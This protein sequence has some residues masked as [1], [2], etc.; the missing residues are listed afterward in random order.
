S[1]ARL[2]RICPPPATAPKDWVLGIDFGTTGVRAALVRLGKPEIVKLGRE[3]VLPA[4]VALDDQGRLLVGAR[5]KALEVER[6]AQVVSGAKRWL[7][8]RLDAATGRR[9]AFALTQDDRGEIAAEVKGQPLTMTRVCAELLRQARQLAQETLGTQLLRAVIGVPAYFNE[10]QRSALRRAAQQAG[11]TVERLVSEPTAAAIAHAATHGLPR[12]RLL[13]V[14]FGGG[15]FDATVLEVE[16]D[17]FEVVATGGDSFLGG[18]DFD[19]RIANL[20]AERFEESTG[21]SL[22][23]DAVAQ[24]RLRLAAETAKI[25]LSS[26]T[27]AQVALPFLATRDGAPVDLRLTLGRAEVESLCQDLV[28]QAVEITR[29]VLGAVRLAP[30]DLDELLLAGGMTQMPV[31]RRGFSELFGRGAVSDLDPATAVAFGAALLGASGD[32]DDRT[33]GLRELL[34]S[35]I[36]VQL[37]NGKLRP[38]FGRHTPLPAERHLDVQAPAG[39]RALRVPVY[40]GKGDDSAKD[41]LLGALEL[42]DLPQGPSSARAI[43]TFAL[44]ADG[45][46]RIH[47]RAGQVERT[48]DLETG[49]GADAPIAVILEEPEAAQRA[50]EGNG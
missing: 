34:A 44:S 28:A 10:R 27:E 26:A 21:L 43:M 40:Q 41:D 46:L 20:L 14:D 3:P 45:V 5:A 6:P 24:Q 36:S 33:L 9:A 12:R 11:L 16:G 29:E 38:V 15:T 48:L 4:V 30:R 31:V 35:T 19:A 32:Q 23:D 2:E 25:S 18:L 49:V 17:D 37:P 42:T 1:R 39:S 8:R 50:E 47:A 22:A 13:V 7:G